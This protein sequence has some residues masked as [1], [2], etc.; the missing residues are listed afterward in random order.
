MTPLNRF[1]LIE[2]VGK[3]IG[4]SSR[5]DSTVESGWHEN[6]EKGRQCNSL[7][8][9]RVRDCKAD[10]L[11]FGPR[12][13][14]SA[15]LPCPLGLDW[16]IQTDGLNSYGLN[17]TIRLV[18]VQSA[19]ARCPAYG[20]SGRYH[21]GW[22][23]RFVVVPWHSCDVRCELAS[24]RFIGLFIRLLYSAHSVPA[25]SGLAN[26]DRW[27]KQLRNLLWNGTIRFVSAQSPRSKMPRLRKKWTIPFRR[28]GISL[29][30]GS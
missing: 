25:R 30:S 10:P 13:I 7:S 2:F 20:K 16:Q 12:F 6:A 15:G 18:S 24:P 5:W 22:N 19:G 8:T 1:G 4:K 3:P 9:P 21:S 26:P 17:G 27:T 23:G 29:P 28:S 14:A 11:K